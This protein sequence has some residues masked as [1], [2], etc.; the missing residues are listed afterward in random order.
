[1]QG[2]PYSIIANPPMGDIFIWRE[3]EDEEEAYPQYTDICPG[4]TGGA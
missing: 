3:N 2:K 1:M 4:D